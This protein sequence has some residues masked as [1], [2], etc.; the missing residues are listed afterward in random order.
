MSGLRV[1]VFG[2]TF[3]PPHIGH[4]IVAG[5]AM[6]SAQL[7]RLLFVP[8]NSSPHKAGQDQT[9]SETRAS[10]V[11]AAIE[12]DPR[13]ELSR[14]ELDR[15]GVSYTIE[16]LTSLAE[17]HPDWAL[18]LVVGADQVSAFHRWKDPRRILDIAQIVAMSRAGESGGE[19]PG[20]PTNR[21]TRVEVTRIDVSSSR[22]RDR[23][24]EG[25]SVRNMVTDPVL[26]VIEREKLYRR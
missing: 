15:G 14:L 17:T 10:M 22:I 23:I 1:G 25:K 11:S 5:E 24:K 2:G 21:M 3:D 13:F 20:I 4:L 12:D 18:S 26:A 6:E 16:T 7:D 8:A 19:T 9:P